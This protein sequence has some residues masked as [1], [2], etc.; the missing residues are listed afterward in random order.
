MSRW[1]GSFPTVRTGAPSG[2]TCIRLGSSSQIAGWNERAGDTCFAT[3]FR[4]PIFLQD[5]LSGF[6][7]SSGPYAP[8]G[9]SPLS[10]PDFFILPARLLHSAPGA[11]SG[12][13]SR[14]ASFP[15]GFHRFSSRPIRHDLA[16][17]RLGFDSAWIR[18]DPYCNGSHLFTASESRPHRLPS[19]VSGRHHSSCRFIRLLRPRSIIRH[20][21]HVCV[22]WERLFKADFFCVRRRD[23]ASVLRLS[24]P[25]SSDPLG[26]HSLNIYTCEPPQ[27]SARAGCFIMTR[28]SPRS[29]MDHFCALLQDIRIIRVFAPLP[30]RGCT[31]SAATPAT[32]PV[33]PFVPFVPFLFLFLFRLFWA[34]LC[35]C[36]ARCSAICKRRMAAGGG[37]NR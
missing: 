29:L 2:A 35:S 36:L 4:F 33:V 1:E 12:R 19:A 23:L 7:T 8:T 20:V 5:P 13:A 15:D 37:D 32:A 24:T 10:A 16:L 17:S 6:D 11:Q 30:F 22:S 25:D 9:F 14:R 28:Q 34:L 21:P 18:H 31:A 27:I 26:R 3:P